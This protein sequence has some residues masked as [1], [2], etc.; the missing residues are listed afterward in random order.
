MDAN[1]QW[2][3]ED[4][5]TWPQNPVYA[6]L[7]EFCKDIKVLN[8]VA[9]RAV[10]DVQDYAKATCDPAHHDNIILV[11]ND[12]RGCITNMRKDNLDNI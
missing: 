7:H 9:E 1:T 6:H 2:L 8:H 4:P 5:S 10:E 3:N 11:A 12:H